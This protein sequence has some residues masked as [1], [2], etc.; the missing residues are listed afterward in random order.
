MGNRGVDLSSSVQ[1][2]RLRHRPGSVVGAARRGWVQAGHGDLSKMFH[3]CYDGRNGVRCVRVE[4]GDAWSNVVR[5]DGSERNCPCCLR[6]NIIHSWA[7]GS[8]T[9]ICR[10]EFTKFVSHC[11]THGQPR[12]KIILSDYPLN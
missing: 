5:K 12:P 1:T 11:I 7:S 6:P 10:R 4:V 8:E 2:T 3:V 9:S